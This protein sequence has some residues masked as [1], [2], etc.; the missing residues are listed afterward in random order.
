M[1]NHPPSDPSRRVSRYVFSR[2]ASNSFFYGVFMSG[3]MMAM[4]GFGMM[5]IIVPE[6]RFGNNYIDLFNVIHAD[7]WG[8]ASLS[9]AIAGY[10]GLFT[11]NLKLWRWAHKFAAFLFTAIALLIAKTFFDTGIGGPT[12]ITTYSALA[13]N[14]WV[15]GA[16]FYRDPFCGL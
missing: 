8:V 11:G 15:R 2:E 14:A 13:A 6:S 10:V 16:N 9:V 12:A 5:T 1:N 3:P 7:I 4:F